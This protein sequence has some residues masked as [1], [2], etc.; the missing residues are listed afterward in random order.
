MTA[1][2]KKYSDQR[3]MAP[4]HDYGRY[5]GDSSDPPPWTRKIQKPAKRGTIS[6][7]A[8]RKAIKEVIAE[9][10]ARQ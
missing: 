4:K 6:R 7:T 10:A 2:K 5:N 8:I 9:H 3:V 1:N